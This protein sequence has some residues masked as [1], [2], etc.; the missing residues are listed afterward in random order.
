MIDVMAPLALVGTPIAL[1][2]AAG[3]V[4]AVPNRAPTRRKSAASRAE[5]PRSAARRR[6]TFSAV[7]VGAAFLLIGAP[8]W[9][10]LTSAPTAGLIAI[11]AGNREKP[12][13]VGE[14][15]SLAAA[16]DLFAACLDSGLA[17]AVAL[18]A[19]TNN[20]RA[21]GSGHE[22]LAQTAALLA[23]GGEPGEAWR[24]VARLPVLADLAIAAQRSASGGVRLAD[25]AR[26]TATGLRTTCR[27]TVTDQAARAG[28]AMTAPLALCFLPA[29]MCLGLA[30]TVIGMVTSLHLW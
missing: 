9:I 21:L 6:A 27:T 12:L 10:V 23:L 5:R 18:V 15:R 20:E 14:M 11:R 1:I 4:M 2:A 22:A 17:T 29:F 30:P 13:S 24:P 3:A 16:L 19:S 28:V 8:W 7:G 25:A 26:E